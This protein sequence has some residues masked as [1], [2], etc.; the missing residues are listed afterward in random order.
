MIFKIN[1]HRDAFNVWFLSLLLYLLLFC[2]ILLLSVFC[3]EYLQNPREGQNLSLWTITRIPFHIRICSRI[4]CFRISTRRW[5]MH[6]WNGIVIGVQIVVGKM[7][8]C[9]LVHW[10][11]NETSIRTKAFSLFV[12]GLSDILR[13]ANFTITSS[14]VTNGL[15]LSYVFFLYQSLDNPYATIVVAQGQHYRFADQTI[16]LNRS[17]NYATILFTRVSIIFFNL[18]DE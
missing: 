4:S 8:E 14:A 3:I 11:L 10:K 5:W 12:I 16:A 18:C 6:A 7:F 9:M 13:K 17:R 1:L 15:L 2:F